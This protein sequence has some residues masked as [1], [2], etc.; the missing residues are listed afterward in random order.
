MFRS[1]V[2]EFLPVV[3]VLAQLATGEVSAQSVSSRFSE[4]RPHISGWAIDSVR[5]RER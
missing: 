2:W 1:T 4:F 5:T 3:I